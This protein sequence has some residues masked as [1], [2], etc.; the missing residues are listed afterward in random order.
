MSC[1]RD[2]NLNFSLTEFPISLNISIR[3]SFIKNKTGEQLLP[4]FR[5]NHTYKL[6]EQ[7]KSNYITEELQI[8]LEN[9]KQEIHLVLMN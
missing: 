5:E 6:D 4:L 1:V 2:S 9:A 7:E 8:K 3:K